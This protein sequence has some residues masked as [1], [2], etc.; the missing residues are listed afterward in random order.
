MKKFEFVREK[1]DFRTSEAYKTLRSN[2]TFCGDDV[3]VIAV[4]SCMPNDG[5]ST[6]SRNIAINFAEAGKRVLFIDADLRKSVMLG[7]IIMEGEL[8]GL[9]HLLSGQ[10]EL[11]EVICQSE[12]KNLNVIFA[13]SYPPNPAELLGNKRFKSLIATMRDSFDYIIID[14]PPLGSVIDSAIVSTV[15]DGVV[16]VLRSARVSYKF[17]N[18]VKAQLEKTGC[19]ILGAVINGVNEK[20]S[21]GYYSRYYKSYYGD[22]YGG[23]NKEKSE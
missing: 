2:L 18:N 23:A 7:K 10:A 8:A 4:T 21:G 1:Q 13:G 14:T 5:K 17:A 19:R 6:I 12:M 9:S 22:Y 16:M 15:C 11:G 3:K 20:E